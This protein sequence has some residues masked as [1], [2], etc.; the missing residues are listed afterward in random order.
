[1]IS[2][3]LYDYEMMHKMNEN[4]EFVEPFKYSCD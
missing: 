3:M 4:E 2:L 1:M